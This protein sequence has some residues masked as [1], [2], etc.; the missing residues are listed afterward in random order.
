MPC[1]LRVA[2]HRE[3]IEP[4][5]SAPADIE[6]TERYSECAIVLVRAR[7]ETTVTAA[8]RSPLG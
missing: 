2:R 4:R 1:E 6:R 8:P 3:P 5:M 7:F